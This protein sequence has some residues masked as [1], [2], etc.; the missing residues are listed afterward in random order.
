MDMDTF[1]RRRRACRVKA[2][3]WLM[4]VCAVAVVWVP[5]ADASSMITG[6]LSGGA[7]QTL[8]P[9]G[10]SGAVAVA[11]DSSASDGVVFTA[12]GGSWSGTI[13]PSAT[14]VDSGGFPAQAAAPAIA[15]GYVVLSQNPALGSNFDDVFVEPA[16][17]WSGT[18]AQSA[19]LMASDGGTLYSAV[20]AGDTVVV[21]GRE[22]P[23]GQG[24]AYVFVKPAGGW[25]GTVTETAKLSDRNGS[26]IGR[27][28]TDGQTVVAAAGSHGDVFVRPQG[29]WTGSLTQQV[30]L[31][32]SG[33]PGGAGLSGQTAFAGQQIFHEP[34]Q[35]WSGSVKPSAGLYAQSVNES[36]AVY[37]GQLAAVSSLNLLGPKHDCPC[38]SIISLFSM[39]KSGW[40]GEL[41]AKPTLGVPSETGLTGLALQDGNLFLSGGGTNVTVYRISAPEGTRPGRPTLLTTRP[42]GSANRQPRLGLSVRRGSGAPPFAS[43]Q[44]SLPAGLSFSRS[45]RWSVIVRSDNSKC[46]GLQLLRIR[47]RAVCAPG[48]QLTISAGKGDIV[49]SPQLLHRVRNAAHEQPGKRRRPVTLRLSITTTDIL[50]FSSRLRS[51]VRT[52]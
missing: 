46:K 51:L 50:G 30:T 24:V 43:V 32:T 42:R 8:G 3:G 48:A 6:T 10:V 40:T 19:R 52:G 44:L 15:A 2:V 33:V 21:N 45:A 36:G 1:G 49:E 20:I 4:V 18:I 23:N 39:P 34:S 16:G 41:T 25:S 31:N 26:S 12:P 7:G 14:L 22:P 38:T 11:V 17:G 9:L 27:V 13:G 37:D 47:L 5:S 29:G 35:G 28:A